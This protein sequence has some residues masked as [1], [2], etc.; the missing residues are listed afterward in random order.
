VI[1]NNA[2]LLTPFGAASRADLG[3]DVNLFAAGGT[4]LGLVVDFRHFSILLP[5]LFMQHAVLT[6]TLTHDHH[7]GILEDEKASSSLWL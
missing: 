7:F 3:P 2:T 4:N 5:S 1:S 6:M